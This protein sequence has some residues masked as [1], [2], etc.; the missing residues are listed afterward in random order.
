MTLGSWRYYEHEVSVE[1]YFVGRG[2]EPGVWVGSGAGVARP[3]GDCGGG[4]AGLPVRRGPPPGLGEPLGL[5]YRQDAKRTVV[6]GYALSFSPPK[7]VSL[8]GAFGGE[9][10]G[11]GGARRPMTARCGRR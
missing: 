1:D 9:G 5:A 4:P 6:T 7:S 8:V 10:G 2:E 11:G 3:V